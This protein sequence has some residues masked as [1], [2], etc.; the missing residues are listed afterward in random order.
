MD[1]RCLG[2]VSEDEEESPV[3]MAELE[4]A[5]HSVRD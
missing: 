4:M 2:P 3:E 1:T 5:E